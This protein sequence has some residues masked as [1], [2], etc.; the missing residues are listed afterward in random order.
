M[1]ILSIDPNAQITSMLDK[2]LNSYGFEYSYVN[3]WKD[4]LKIIQEQNF[5][6]VLL[7][8]ALPELSGVDIIDTL[9]KE[10]LLYK[11]KIILFTASSMTDKEMH[12]LLNRGVHSYIRKPID[13]DQL[14]ERLNQIGAEL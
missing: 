3:N 5:D 4:G 10:N 9:E 8:L 6:L 11:K 14:I 2:V 1:K 12:Y 13:I 7:D